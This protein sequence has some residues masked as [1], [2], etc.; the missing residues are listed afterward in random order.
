VRHGRAL[1]IIAEL[2][3]ASQLSSGAFP[4]SVA[5]ASAGRH[6]GGTGRVL[7]S[8]VRAPHGREQSRQPA[9]WGLL[10]GDQASR[11]K[12]RAVPGRASHTAARSGLGTQERGTHDAQ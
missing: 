1:R 7:P 3:R 12:L 5:S 10:R 6:V 4:V 8:P 11:N 2:I 9:G